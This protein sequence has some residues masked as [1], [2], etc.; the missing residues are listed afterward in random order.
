MFSA[1]T[2][3][4][5]TPNE[6]FFALDPIYRFSL[7]VAASKSNAKIENYYTEADNGLE[8]EWKGRIWCNP[9]YGK[10]V[11]KW[12]EKCRREI[13]IGNC[14]VAVFLLPARTDTKWFHEY[15][16]DKV[17]HHP[18]TGVQLQLLAGRLRFEGATSGAPFPS[19]I[20][21]FKPVR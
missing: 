12:L 7:D 19:M 6:L 17:S 3:E 11:G 18:R 21:V 16:W 9:P 1:K 4:W 15:V 14:D 5:E 20:V 8:K 2:H 10:G 13:E